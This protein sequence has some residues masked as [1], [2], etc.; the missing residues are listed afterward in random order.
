MS[1]GCLRIT[2]ILLLLITSIARGSTPTTAPSSADTIAPLT[3]IHAHN[4]YQH[5]RPLFDALDCGI[6]SV[7][8]DI[9][10]VGN[11]LLVAHKTEECV[12]GRTLQS[13]YLDPVRDRVR[14]NGGHV[15]PAAPDVSLRL[16]VDIKT[17]SLSTYEA[18]RTALQPYREML[19][20]ITG[21][22]KEDRR[23]VTV[24]L[25]GNAPPRAH[26]T[27]EP[28]RYAKFDGVL[29]DLSDPAT[30][31]PPE[32]VDLISGEWKKSF[33]WTGVGPMPKLERQLLRELASRSNRIGRPLRFW[34][35]PDTPEVWRELL[36]AKI[37]LINTDDLRGCSAFVRGRR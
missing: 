34:G 32:L 11:E 5:A 12:P 6:A 4:D 29:T 31:P 8:A 18:L 22:G 28:V 3:D 1:C 26:V 27:A 16:L 36:D 20:S 24:V 13:L 21:D 19:T 23:A 2:L 37:G 17:D 9:H 15:F 7:E 33:T 10:L 25:T 30:A 35:A 14:A